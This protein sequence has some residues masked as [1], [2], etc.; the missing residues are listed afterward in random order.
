MGYNEV[1]NEATA[2]VSTLGVQSSGQIQNQKQIK[3]PQIAMHVE[4][5][6]K[7][8]AAQ[9]DIIDRLSSKLSPALS[10][11]EGPGLD[12]CNKA[13]VEPTCPLANFMRMMA[14]QV[15]TNTRLLNDLILR[16]EL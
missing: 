2:P 6:Q 4:I 16:I 15:V 11:P 12:Q 9:R 14:D 3:A 5:L 1:Y 13:L 10:L 8:I 7:E